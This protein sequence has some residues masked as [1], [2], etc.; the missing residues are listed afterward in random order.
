VSA[1][2]EATRARYAITG[3]PAPVGEERCTRTTRKGEQ[4][5]CRKAPNADIC[6]QHQRQDGRK[7]NQ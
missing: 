1:I 6:Q 5:R 3:W 7:K 2:D 4:C